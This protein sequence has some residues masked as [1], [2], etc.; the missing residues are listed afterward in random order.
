M[1][2]QESLQYILRLGVDRIRNH[3]RDLTDRLQEE[4]PKRGY[5]SIT[6]QGNESPILAFV[7]PHPE[8]ALASCRS[9]DVH[10]AMR[11]GNKMRLSPSVYNNHEDIDRLFEALP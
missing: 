9:A 1:C 7:A 5:K 3:A 4:L 6:P 8:A 11:F 2:A 10:I